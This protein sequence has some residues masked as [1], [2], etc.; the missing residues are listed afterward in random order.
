M[1]WNDLENKFQELNIHSTTPS[2]NATFEE[3]MNR[4]KKKKRRII[5]YWSFAGLLFIGGLGVALNTKPS[6]LNP[7]N[8]NKVLVE[9]NKNTGADNKIVEVSKEIDPDISISTN[10][11]NYE[12]TESRTL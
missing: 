8:S 9:K 2:A 11:Q 5:A 12:N 1:N 6:G 4:R 10:Q 7:N 3:V